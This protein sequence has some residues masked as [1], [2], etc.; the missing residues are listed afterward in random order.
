MENRLPGIVYIGYMRAGSTYLRSYFSQ[1]PDISWSRRAWAFQLE[2]SDEERRQKYSHLFAGGDPHSCHIDMYEGLSLGYVLANPSIEDFSTSAFPDWSAEWAVTPG[3]PMDGKI[4]VPS[5]EEIAR[6]IRSILPDSKILIVL[7]N[8]VDWLRSMYL[9]YS[10]HYHPQ[11]RGFLDFL[12]TIEGKATL[13]SACYSHT[14]ESY[15]RHFGKERIHVVLF[16]ELIQKEEETLRAL[17]RFL[18][19]SGLPMDRGKANRNQGMNG[20]P[21]IG[22]PVSFWASPRSLFRKKEAEE[23]KS[24][25]NSQEIRF[26]RAMYAV[27]NYQTSV[28]LDRDLSAWGYPT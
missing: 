10:P 17:C 6:R 3:T 16:E 26:I 25:L 23:A 8:Q 9:H 21:E 27:S 18:G 19:V 13:A 15:R 20:L 28:W 2:K 4:V 7:R 1:H 12:D 14:L 24:V 22:S 5:H 11:R